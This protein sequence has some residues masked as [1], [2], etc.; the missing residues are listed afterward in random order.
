QT[1]IGSVKSKT[2][3]TA[4]V[5]NSE[6]KG[7]WGICTLPDG[8]LLISG[9]PGSMQ[10]VTTDGKIVKTITGFPAVQFQGQGGL[11]DV[12]ADPQF[13]KNRMVYWTYAQPGE[14]ATLA[15][16]KGKL[17]ADETKLEDVSVIWEAF[18]RYRG[19]GQFGSRIV[20]DKQGNLFVS[21]GDR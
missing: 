13:A 12:K 18:P 11:L 8:R 7:P 9:K 21:S 1:R 2:A 16:A 6:L 15:V 14:G 20:F 5:I 3:Y 4:T 10:I 17:S 19:S